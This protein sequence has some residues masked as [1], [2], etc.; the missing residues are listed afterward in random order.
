MNRQ[1]PGTRV[2]E[3]LM[4][5]RR[6][7]TMDEVIAA[8]G[9]PQYNVL[10]RLEARG[11]RIRKVKEGQITR[12]FAE[13]PAAPSY[14]ATVTSKGQ[15]TIPKEVRE[16]LRLGPGQAVRF[17]LDDGRAVMAPAY[18]RLSELVGILPR[19][20]RV[21]SIEEMDEAIAEGAARR[22]RRS[23]GKPR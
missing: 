2:A 7:A 17:S 8:T 14:E 11:Y 5:R 12:Y 19:P 10:R 18:K 15:V 20:R 9:G 3:R 4:A 6:G 23:V 22:F 16:R 13:P 1:M 21:V